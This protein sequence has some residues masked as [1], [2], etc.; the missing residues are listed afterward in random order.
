MHE[1]D[2]FMYKV[3]KRRKKKILKVSVSKQANLGS[4]CVC[5]H[6]CVHVHI[7]MLSLLSSLSE[8]AIERRNNSST[9]NTRRSSGVLA[10]NG[11]YAKCSQSYPKLIHLV[12]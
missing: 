3:K 7:F 10:E 9:I 5:V 6:V 1:L 2:C 12:N 4:V 8:V 11:L